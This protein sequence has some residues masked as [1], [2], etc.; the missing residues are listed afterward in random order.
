MNNNSEIQNPN[1]KILRILLIEDN[2]GDVR[3][4]KEMLSESKMATFDVE[5]ADRL[6]SGLELIA[7]NRFDVILLDLGLPDSQGLSTLTKLSEIKPE[8]PV[9]VLTGFKD[10]SVGVQAVKEG[11]Q[12][13]L[14][15]GQVDNNLLAHSIKYAIER[16]KAEEARWESEV[17][18]RRLHD[19]MTDCFVEVAM[20]GEIVD[21]NRSY[22]EMLGY[23]EEEIRKLRYQ[24]ITPA[25]WHEFE[26]KI[27]VQVMTQGYS[28][29]YEKEYIRKD[30][31]I[32]PVE[33]RT[34][35]IK[36]EKGENEGMWAIVRDITE[37]KKA[38]ERIARLNKLYSIMSKVNEAIVRIR[39]SEELFNEVCRIVVEDGMFRMVWIGIVD[40]D[41]LMVKPA[42]IYGHEDGYLKEKLISADKSIPEGRGPTGTAIQNRG[43]FIC[44][45]IENDP[46]MIPWRDRA[47]KRGY[48]SSA[49][50]VLKKA[51]KIIGT[52]NVYSSEAYFFQE[53]EVKLLITLA[54]DI[55]YA[56]DSIESEQKRKK[57]EEVLQKSEAFI[58]NILESVEEGFIVIDREYGIISANKAYSNA[59]KMPIE[60]IIGK[61]CY[62][63]SHH[64]NKP[65]YETGEDCSV[66]HVFETGE[67][68]V[69]THTHFDKDRNPVYVETRA[70]PIKDASGIVVSAIE[71][72]QDITEKMTADKEI[73]ERVRELEE[74]YKMAVG[75]E[76]RMKE[77]KKQINNL[78]EELKK[79]K[80]S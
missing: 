21:V 45:D 51:G 80:K 47:L 8:A 60:D 49:A 4:I 70:Y 9:I 63:V 10:E 2:P 53:E 38:E 66:K 29:V 14:I 43:Y 74:F 34:F 40:P 18:Y 6:S 52:I 15:K 12:D 50:F 73:K 76:L 1:S 17:R 26:Q 11:A 5:T 56:M 33:L 32:F 77:L 42:A 31:T 23:S 55:S 3:L 75:R 61:H 19:S 46:I 79:Y 35:L 48:R 27:I 24:D 65:C 54:D 44:N 71:T 36:N 67:S 58:R 25:R 37:R 16:N 68:H 57:A 39:N 64:V 72:I 78:E 22:L 59:V 30:G 20:P 62:E 13:Y 28:D 41:T 7:N 69:I